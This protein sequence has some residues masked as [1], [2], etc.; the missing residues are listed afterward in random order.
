MLT[1]DQKII[2]AEFRKYLRIEEGIKGNM[3]NN[4]INAAEN[5]LP[6]LIRE[7]VRDDFGC[8][9]DDIYTVEEMLSCSLR[10]K[11]D[12]EIMAARSGYIS[13]KAMDAYIRFYTKKH[14]IDLKAIQIPD[15]ATDTLRD[16]SDEEESDKYEGRL[17]EAKVLRRQRNRTARQKCLEESGYTCYVCGFNFEKAYGEIGKGFLEVHHT[18]PLATY[19]DEHVIPQS[20]LCALCS[21]CHSMVHRRREVLDVDELKTLYDANKK[22]TT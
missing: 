17:T 6:A 13:S 12:D 4:L 15:S 9:Y 18:K 16:E 5:S 3:L 11:S 8:I 10:L 20:E 2:H 1:E 22:K 21:N 19:D 14:G 7:Y